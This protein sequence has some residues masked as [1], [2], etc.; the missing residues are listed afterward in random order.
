[1]ENNKNKV[2]YCLRS[3]AMDGMVRFFCTISTNL[4]EEARRR[5]NTYPTATAALK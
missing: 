2:N 5:H 3:I 4:C 1:M